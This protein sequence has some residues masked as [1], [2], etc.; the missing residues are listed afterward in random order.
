MEAIEVSGMSEVSKDKKMDRYTQDGVGKKR[1]R[2]TAE[3]RAQVREEKERQEWEA[4][5]ACTAHP[6][7]HA[8]KDGKCVAL[9]DNYFSGRG[10]PFYKD[11]DKNR[12]EQRECLE[13]LVRA[14]RADLIEKYEKVLLELGIFDTEDGYT[15]RVAGELKRYSDECLEEFLA[16]AA[17]SGGSDSIPAGTVSGEDDW[18]D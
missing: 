17:A 3:E 15:D 6:D 5:P 10:C 16:D 2:R 11:R 14:G 12:K 4:M 18:D 9:S 7:C 13:S 1:T 8:W